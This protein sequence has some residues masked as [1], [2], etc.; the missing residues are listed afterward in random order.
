MAAATNPNFLVNMGG[1]NYCDQVESGI[2][3]RTQFKLAGTYPL[4][5]Y[6]IIISGSYQGLPGYILGT[7]RR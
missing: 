6:G 5:W 2:P 7:S 1:V 4:P 3:W